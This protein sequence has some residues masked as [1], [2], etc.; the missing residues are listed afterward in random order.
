MRF[1]VKLLLIIFLLTSFS[2]DA[3]AELY[4]FNPV[5][6]YEVYSYTNGGGLLFKVYID[7]I[8]VDYNKILNAFGDRTVKADINIS[9]PAIS[10]D[11]LAF[12]SNIPFTSTQTYPIPGIGQG[13]IS[14]EFAIN[15]VSY[16]LNSTTALP[17]DP[18]TLG[19]SGDFDGQA[20]VEISGSIIINGNSYQYHYIPEAG[21]LN[22]NF[23]QNTNWL[24]DTNFPVLGLDLYV[25]GRAESEQTI[26]SEI[27]DGHQLE[28]AVLAGT[29]WFDYQAVGHHVPV[30]GAVLLFG[31]GL[32]GLG[33]L[34]WRGR[35]G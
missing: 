8:E 7:E 14:F 11:T 12:S 34:K 17:I 31:T 27:I 19:F 6:P 28:I 29:A 32:V 4:D 2:N 9:D 15:E 3:F 21:S 16:Y 18:I 23:T 30:P 20:Q 10:F 33:L 5:N 25:S 1:L 22:V 35:Q 24:D 26:F 13:S